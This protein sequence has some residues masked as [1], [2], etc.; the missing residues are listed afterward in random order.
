[1]RL[2][3]IFTLFLFSSIFSQQK[4]SNKTVKKYTL[5]NCIELALQNN[6]KIKAVKLG[7]D[8]SESHIQ[9]LKSA[10]YPQ[11]DL[12]ISTVTLD[13]DPNFIFPSF[14]MEIAPIDLGGV[15]LQSDPITVAEQNVKLMDKFSVLGSINMQYALWTGGYLKALNNQA[16]TALKISKLQTE[17][18][19][20]DLISEVKKRYY[21]VIMLKKLLVVSEEI[22]SILNAVLK[23]TEKIYEGGS[24]TVSTT[25]YLKYKMYIS[26]FNTVM[27]EIK[28]KNDLAK[29]ALLN[30][31]GLKSDSEFQLEDAQPLD[32]LTINDHL[33][34]VS[35]AYAS[36]PLWEIAN[37]AK[38]VFEYKIDEIKSEYYPKFGLFA[39]YQ[40]IHNNY[41]Y[42]MVTPTNKSQWLL[43]VGMEM[44]IFNGF[45]TSNKQE[46]EEIKL[47][48]LEE[49]INELNNGI[50][51]LAYKAAL[52]VNSGYEKL[53]EFRKLEAIAKKNR[54]IIENAYNNDLLET[55]DFIE[56]HLYESFVLSQLY[57][58]EYNYSIALADLENIIGKSK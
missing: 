24:I 58:A 4:N 22:S 33:E 42:G 25:D 55:K 23:L 49:K 48:Q 57:N 11:V 13:E 20:N 44:S 21:A 38:K 39:G 46:E 51:I 26:F 1:M 28:T 30:S 16:E 45:R 43:G 8:I 41:N 54:R 40:A 9:Q 52:E 35:L 36:N 2:I 3:L 14:T 19:E 56:A 32:S 6:P 7:E 10:N 17:K 53:L 29:A 27:L 34:I 50:N 18:S 15:V 5:I 31:I 12:R 37:N 47:L